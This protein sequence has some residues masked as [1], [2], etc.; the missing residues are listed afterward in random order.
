ML[1]SL[2]NNVFENNMGKLHF[3]HFL[4]T[5]YSAI[6]TQSICQLQMLW[7]LNCPTLVYGKY[8]RTCFRTTLK[9]NLKSGLLQQ[10]VS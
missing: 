5:A 6:S 3:L 2:K 9:G 10:V 4:L 1:M 7:T 8:S